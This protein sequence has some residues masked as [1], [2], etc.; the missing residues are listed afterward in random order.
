MDTSLKQTLKAKA[1]HLKPVVMIGSKG[2]TEAIIK[3]T[4]SALC[5]HEL[6]KVKLAVEKEEKK[7]MLEQLCEKNKAALVQV[8]GNIAILYRKNDG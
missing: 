4:D 5:A 1:H 8:I 2:L 6:I 7:P 3:E